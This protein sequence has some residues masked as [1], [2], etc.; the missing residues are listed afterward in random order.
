MSENADEFHPERVPGAEHATADD[1]KFTDYLL[2]ENHSQ[3]GAGKARFFRTLGY[4]QSNWEKLRSTF[5][6]QLP[7]VRGRYMR[8]NDPWGDNYEAVITI[9]TE[10]GP[11]EVRTFWE[12]RPGSGAKFLTAYPRPRSGGVVS[13]E[14]TA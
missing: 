14:R 5:L 7:R 4:D 6:D 13:G 2:N 12:V 8:G 11:T 10:E 1:R 9:E 3:G